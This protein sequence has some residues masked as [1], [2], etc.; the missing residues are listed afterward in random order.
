MDSTGKQGSA[1]L[2]L[3]NTSSIFIDH[4][5]NFCVA[6]GDNDRIQKFST[7]STNSGVT[8]TGSS[9]IMK[10]PVGGVINVSTF[11]TLLGFVNSI[12]SNLVLDVC[13]SVYA[14]ESLNGSILKISSSNST[15]EQI[16]SNLISPNDFALDPYGNLYIVGRDVNR[17]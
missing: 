14:V 1:N 15:G 7:K 13:N 16:A 17:V 5:G 2:Q 11:A 12:P 9:R 6:D 4:Y 8:I 10:Y 3:S